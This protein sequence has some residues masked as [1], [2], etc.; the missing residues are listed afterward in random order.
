MTSTIWSLKEEQIRK[1]G[2][3]DSKISVWIRSPRFLQAANAWYLNWKRREHVSICASTTNDR[4]YLP[5]DP[6]RIH[7]TVL[8][9]PCNRCANQADVIFRQ[10]F[11]ISGTRG[12][13]S[14]IWR[15]GRD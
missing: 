1:R 2:C 6:V 9:E 14:A 12:Q 7:N 15:E 5:L 3:P 10:G 4:I 8:G 13:T 11:Q